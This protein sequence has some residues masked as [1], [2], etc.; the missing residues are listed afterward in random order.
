MPMRCLIRGVEYNSVKEA[1]DHFG[2]PTSSVYKMIDQ[3][4][5]DYVGVG[6]GNS[7]AKN[8]TILGVSF[9]SIK[10]MSLELGI[11]YHRARY[12]ASYSNPKKYKKFNEIRERIE[13]Y[14]G[15]AL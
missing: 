7:A 3:S 5:A 12:I 13:I 6:K 9:S 15:N 1:A 4:R 8:I 10:E 2:V 11:K 14:K